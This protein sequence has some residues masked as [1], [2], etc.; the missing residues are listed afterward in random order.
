MSQKERSTLVTVSKKYQHLNMWSVSLEKQ[1][2][3]FGLT[4]LKFALYFTKQTVVNYLIFVALMSLEI[5]SVT[6]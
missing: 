2:F 4:Q 5:H 1:N 3:I 6:K